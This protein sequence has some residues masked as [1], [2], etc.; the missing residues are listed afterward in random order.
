[1]F[2]GVFGFKDASSL[3]AARK[4]RMGEFYRSYFPEGRHKLKPPYIKQ[5]EDYLERAFSDDVGVT[6]FLP[7][8]EEEE[9]N[10]TFKHPH[11]WSQLS[12][13]EKADLIVINNMIKLKCVS[14]FSCHYFKEVSSLNVAI[15][16]QLN[17]FSRL[18]INAPQEDQLDLDSIL[19]EIKRTRTKIN[20]HQND[21]KD[22]F[23]PKTKE[24]L[25]L[26][27]LIT[28]RDTQLLSVNGRPIS[29]SQ[30]QEVLS[31]SQSETL[32]NSQIF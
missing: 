5:A 1:M 2:S 29:L 11:N 6:V 19:L 9:S 24:D 30:G 16:E 13:Q 18:D 23:K 14:D 32:R 20:Q 25:S 4:N 22:S 17:R 12:S 31:T 15:E 10:P 7:M 21:S 28:N 3:A 26:L 8:V 27:G